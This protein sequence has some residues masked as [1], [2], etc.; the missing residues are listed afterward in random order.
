MKMLK[1]TEAD[2][3]LFRETCAHLPSAEVKPMFGNL[4]AFA[5][6]NMFAGLFGSEIGLRLSEA[7]RAVLARVAWAGVFGPP[8]RSMKE[9]VTVRLRSC[10]TSQGT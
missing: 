3:H 5:N 1:P 9:Y 4:A 6:G 8:D 2:K 7:D 10:V